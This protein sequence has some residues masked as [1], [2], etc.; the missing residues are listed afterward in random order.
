MLPH[1]TSPKLRPPPDL[2]VTPA[3]KLPCPLHLKAAESQA[4]PPTQSMAESPR[5]RHANLHGKLA[6]ELQPKRSGL[7][8]TSGRRL[9]EAARTV[10][11]LQITVSV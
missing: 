10:A 5:Q 2:G 9:R 4:L 6:P 1:P 8:E 3:L 7:N 11:L